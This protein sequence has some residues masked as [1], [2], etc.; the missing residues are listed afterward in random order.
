MS[1]VKIPKKQ[2]VIKDFD[3]KEIKY[4]KINFKNTSIIVKNKNII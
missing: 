1:K 4:G 3:G 2:V